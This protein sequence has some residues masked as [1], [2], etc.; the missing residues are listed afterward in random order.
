MALKNGVII[1]GSA[2]IAAKVPTAQYKVKCNHDAEFGCGKE[3]DV[4]VELPL[5]HPDPDRALRGYLCD[6]CGKKHQAALT[7]T[8]ERF[9]ALVAKMFD[10][11]VGPSTVTNRQL[12]EVLVDRLHKL[13]GKSSKQA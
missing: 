2:T 3:L 4:T 8:E 9:N 11:S 5:Q 7:A 10:P 1:E 13:E 6:G 12:I